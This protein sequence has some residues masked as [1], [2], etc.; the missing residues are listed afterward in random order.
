MTVADNTFRSAMRHWVSGVTVVTAAQR[1]ANPVGITVSSFTSVSMEPPLV[2]V[3]IHKETESAA[4][5]VAVQCFGVNILDANQ[6]DLSGRFAG[7]DPGFPKDSDR[8]RDLTV[9]HLTTGAPILDAALVA[10]DCKVQTTTDGG[11]HHIFIAQVEAVVMREAD[12]MP[13]VYYNRD[14]PRLD[15]SKNGT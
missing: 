15:F 6:S 14:Y 11:T 5:I 7:Y 4:A 13:L 12:A 10:F 8:F 1:S 3:C 9:S 2:L